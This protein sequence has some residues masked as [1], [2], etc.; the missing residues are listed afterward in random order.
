MLRQ[1]PDRVIDLLDGRG[2]VVDL[3]Q[4]RCFVLLMFLENLLA[5]LDELFHILWPMPFQKLQ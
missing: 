2:R 4:R 5:M 3:T 1:V